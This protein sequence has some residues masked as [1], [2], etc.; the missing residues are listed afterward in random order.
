MITM[1]ARGA[2][3]AVLASTAS[4]RTQVVSSY[5]INNTLATY[6]RSSASCSR[7]KYAISSGSDDRLVSCSKLMSV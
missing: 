7:R 5:E 4:D 3:A 1:S 6:E 2:V